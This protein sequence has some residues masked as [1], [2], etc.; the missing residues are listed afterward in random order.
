MFLPSYFV[1]LATPLCLLTR[2]ILWLEN[3]L[4]TPLTDR[5]E[6]A[7]RVA[8]ERSN[9]RFGRFYH[10]YL[11]KKVISNIWRTISRDSVLR[12]TQSLDR[13]DYIALD[14]ALTERR[15]LLLALPHHG[16]YIN[17]IVSV[18]ERV[19]RSRDIY[20]F[21]GDPETHSG[22]EVFDLLCKRIWTNDSQSGVHIIYDNRG[23]MVKAI[24]ALKEGSAVIIMP[25]VFKNELDTFQISFCGRAMNIMLGTA[26]LARKTKSAI[27]PIVC[28]PVGYGMSFST[29]IG[30]YILPVHPFESEG[31]GDVDLL[32]YRTMLK[33]FRYY[34]TVMDR[35]I[36]YWQ[37]A[38]QMYC[39]DV[40]ITGLDERGMMEAVDA[41]LEDAKLH[42]PSAFQL[43]LDSSTCS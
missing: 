29:D 36:M 30:P 12:M 7:L 20:I 26:V 19:R 39:H 8:C 23:G 11:Q 41:L 13:S 38:R 37:F 34:E 5:D 18:V 4:E 25:D 40:D 33:V 22:N 42:V 32:N 6:A 1:A 14:S 2:R 28:R 27:L 31:E 10:W 15:G 24:R 17:T 3:Y 16:L 35:C 21:Y 43:P 9:I